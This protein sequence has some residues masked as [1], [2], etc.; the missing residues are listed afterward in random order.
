MPGHDVQF[1]AALVRDFAADQRLGDHADHLAAR[2]Q[3]GVGHRAH[4]AQPPA[5]IDHADAARGQPAPT[6]RAVR[7]RRGS[8]GVADPQ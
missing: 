8:A 2:R 4:Q 5:A 1:G 3:R 7:Y 6:A